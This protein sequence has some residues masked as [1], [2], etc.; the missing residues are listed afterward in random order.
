MNEDLKYINVIY[1]TETKSDIFDSQW[2]LPVPNKQVKKCTS[3]QTYNE[4]VFRSLVKEI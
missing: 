3:I 4:S 1:K 2:S